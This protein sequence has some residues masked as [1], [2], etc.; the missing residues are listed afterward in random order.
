MS[1]ETSGM[2]AGR[3]RRWLAW[4]AAAVAV[5]ALAI[6][7]PLAPVGDEVQQF[8]GPTMGT[9]FTVSVDADLPEDERQRVQT[10]IEAGLDRVTRLMSTYEPTS[11]LSLFNAYADTAPFAVDPEV[12]EVLTLAREVSE[13]SD[14]AFDVTVAPVVDAWGFGP[15]DPVGPLP[16]AT[17]LAELL[18]YV[19]YD[20]LTLDRAAG[21]VA[22][23]D[24]RVR[25]DLS[26][27]AQGYASDVVAATLADMGYMSFLVDIGGEIRVSG[28]RR[29][30]R[31]WR[32]GIESPSASVPVWGTVELSA[33]EG[34]A[35]SGDYRNW[36]EEGGVRYA[37]II[38]PHTGRPI[39]MRGASVTVV[40]ETAALADA[41]AT[42]LCVLGPEAGFEMA[43]RE[44]IAAAFITT[45]PGGI[46]SR[47]TPAMSSRAGV[48]GPES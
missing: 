40:H 6:W 28:L 31:P 9:T 5:S 21:T 43:R 4:G 44:G 36:F 7:R 17:R 20:R 42:A 48:E 30:G 32:V 10:A 37:H 13:R 47:L 8:V 39:P 34:V 29:S 22:K 38:D 26:A 45:G 16:D 15:T 11:E 25:V 23:A 1:V 2:G 35:T 14:G 41:W 3:R 18:T 19:G 46:E 27:I 24:P 12:V 33:S